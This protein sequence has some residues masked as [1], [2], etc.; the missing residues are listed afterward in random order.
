MVG[1]IASGQRRH[2]GG[3]DRVSNQA[4]NTNRKRQC[5]HY[6]VLRPPYAVLAE[7]S[8]RRTH[9]FAIMLRSLMQYNKIGLTLQQILLLQQPVS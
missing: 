6:Q 4:C 1:S 7:V 2:E 9:P 5:R 8:A 3:F